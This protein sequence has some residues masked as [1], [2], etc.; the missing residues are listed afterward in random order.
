MTK[1]GVHH[2]LAM[3]TEEVHLQTIWNQYGTTIEPTDTSTTSTYKSVN[4]PLQLPPF[5]HPPICRVANNTMARAAVSYT[6]MDDLAQ[7]PIA[8]SALEVLRTCPTQRK[9]LLASLGAVDPS[10]SNLITFDIEN[11]EPCMILTISFEIMVSIWNL[12]VH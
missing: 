12:V 2:L 9:V 1:T 4:A 8:M 5:P 10:K 6:I 11:G 7:T 3:T